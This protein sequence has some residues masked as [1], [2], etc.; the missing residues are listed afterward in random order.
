MK[1]ARR[2]LIVVDES[3]AELTDRMVAYVAEILAHLSGVEVY[4][5]AVLESTPPQFLEFCNIDDMQ[6]AHAN[7]TAGSGPYME[8]MRESIAHA[9]PAV[10]NARLALEKAGI[11]PTAIHEHYEASIHERRIAQ[12]A[13]DLA[14]GHG[15]DTLVISRPHLSWHRQLFEPDP[16]RELL[17]KGDRI[18]IWVVE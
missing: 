13:L 1:P 18:V 3:A 9:Q 5:L 6:H 12:H 14:H 15:C 8:W 7:T 17:R 4:L 16:A 11:P 2:V 10:A